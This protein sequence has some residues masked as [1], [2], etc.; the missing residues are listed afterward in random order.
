MQK[1]LILFDSKY[2]STQEIAEK[3]ALV[4][5]PAMLI[6][7]EEFAKEHENYDMYVIMSPIYS[8]SISE[9]ILKFIIDNRHWL[10]TKKIALI[11]TSLMGKRGESY[12]NIIEEIL[13]GAVVYK[14]ALG[15]RLNVSSLDG[16][17]LEALR[18]FS[19]KVNFPLKDY[20]MISVA[21]IINASM[22]VKRLRDSF[23]SC[24]PENKLKFHVEEFLNCHNTCTLSTFG[25]DSIRS[26]PIEYNYKDGY[27]YFITEGGEKYANLLVN[28]KVSISVYE[29]FESMVKLAGMQLSGEAELLD[30]GG[31]EYKDALSIK[32]I[33]IENV[34]TLPM[35]LNVFR[36]KLNRAEFLYSKFKTL[37]YEARQIYK[38]NLNDF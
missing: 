11:C 28:R 37:G 22:E 25:N 35:R 19:E 9:K 24:I 21:D 5:G 30:F 18:S 7:P 13:K 17:D 15:G 33:S 20:N 2:G 31:R 26:T 29:P 38:F 1:T 8:E 16:S 14:A 27:M 36:V 4:L 6:R 12:L 32:G 10:I 3:M 23:I 34:L